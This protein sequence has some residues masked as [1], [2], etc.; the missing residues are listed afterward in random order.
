[1]KTV[2]LVAL[3][4]KHWTNFALNMS[5]KLS[6]QG[7]P[8]IIAM[9]SRLGE[10]QLFLK[11]IKYNAK[12]VYYLTDYIKADAHNKKECGEDCYVIP[13]K[14][15]MADFNRNYYLRAHSFLFNSNWHDIKD[16]LASF[17]SKIFREN[18]ISVVIHDTVS[19]SFSYVS[20]L[21]ARHKNIPYYGLVGAKVPGRYEIRKSI[22]EEHLKVKNIYDS[23]KNTRDEITEDDIKWATDYL[24]RIDEQVPSYM[25]TGILNRISF[26]NILNLKYFKLFVG[27]ILFSIMERE[28]VRN[29]ILREQPVKANL[30]SFL[31]NF[32]RNI[33]KRTAIKLMENV[34]TKW[35]DNHDFYVYPLHYQP[36]ASTLIGSPHFNNQIDFI[37]NAAFSLPPNHYL[38]VKEH[39]SNYAFPNNDFYRIIKALPNVKLVSPY[40]NIKDLIR[41]SK[42]LITLTSTAGFEAVL[43]NKPVY[44]FGGVFYEFHPLCKKIY[45]WTQLEKELQIEPVIKDYDNI[46]F[47]LAYRKYTRP[48]KLDFN[49]SD[50]LVS[51]DL[52]NVVKEEIIEKELNKIY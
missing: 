51:D 50:F 21:I 10:Y 22:Y 38:L 47:L 39:I 41:K 12:K 27:T 6:R 18:E 24:S 52:L 42:G 15:V 46:S 11:R 28:Q 49:V 40:M 32:N 5:E 30:R 25:K 9:E 2:L 4:D 36:E 14:V 3:G 48:H 43:L 13:E 45:S 16:K 7:I 35:C 23:I 1:M 8:V 29:L 34:T 33:K 17:Y 19:T 31:R 26:R 20:Y 44:I 37:I